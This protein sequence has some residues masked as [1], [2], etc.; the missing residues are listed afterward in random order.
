M[1]ERGSTE[2]D[3]QQA[4][5]R[6]LGRAKQMKMDAREDLEK[7]TAGQAASRAKKIAELKSKYEQA[8][9]K[10]EQGREKNQSLLNPTAF[11][12]FL[13]EWTTESDEAERAYRLELTRMQGAHETQLGNDKEALRRLVVEMSLFDDSVSL[14]RPTA[15]L[16]EDISRA[17]IARWSEELKNRCSALEVL[18]SFRVIET[19]RIMSSK[20]AQDEY[21]S[22]KNS[23]MGRRGG[24]GPESA[25]IDERSMANVSLTRLKE[26]KR[27]VEEGLA[28]L[29]DAEVLLRRAIRLTSHERELLPLFRVISGNE[30]YPKACQYN[31]LTIAVVL[32]MN[33]TFDQRANCFFQ[34][35]P[36]AQSGLFDRK[37][38]VDSVI[39][40]NE[41]LYRLKLLPYK[42][43]IEEMESL[44]GRFFAELRATTALTQFEAK[45]FLS[46]LFCRSKYYSDLFG[47]D[48]HSLFSTYQRQAMNV[49]LFVIF[50]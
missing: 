32:Q 35:F 40:L 45:Q 17:E 5:V 13:T 42:V 22:L 3:L 25:A 27:A 19:R 28:C 23:L 34:V 24:K 21:T 36:S 8:R 16:L 14:E 43:A 50:K 15:A 26:S 44:V 10:R 9:E 37:Y 49:C 12:I 31:L 39:L 38:L 1:D 48:R 2:D 4:E 46:S 7:R 47:L 18:E 11:R 41:V 33:G 29:S 30:E 6:A 20:V